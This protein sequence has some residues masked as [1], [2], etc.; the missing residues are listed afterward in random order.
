MKTTLTN[1]RLVNCGINSQYSKIR[2][3]LCKLYFVLYNILIFNTSL[4]NAM[5]KLW[6]NYL[7]ITPIF[8]I[9]HSLDI[10]LTN[11]Y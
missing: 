7:K 5:G 10:I 6:V 4:Q 2:N 3:I 11:D 9:S 1:Q 8:T